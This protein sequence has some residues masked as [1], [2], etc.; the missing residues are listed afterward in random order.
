MIKERK[1]LLENTKVSSREKESVLRKDSISKNLRGDFEEANSEE[2]EDVKNNEGT[3]YFETPVLKPKRELRGK[4]KSTLG[5]VKLSPSLLNISQ[6]SRT[7]LVLIKHLISFENLKYLKNLKSEIKELIDNFKNDNSHTNEF[8]TKLNEIL[9]S[10]IFIEIYDNILTK[11]LQNFYKSINT[12]QDFISRIENI[13]LYYYKTKNN[14]T[15]HQL[16]NLVNFLPNNNNTYKTL[17]SVS[18]IKLSHPSVEEK[19]FYYN[20]SSSTNDLS[21][22]KLKK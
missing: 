5:I 10:N 8:N 11:Y 2:N 20:F 12:N 1:V 3:S 21:P 13:L 22:D 4:F 19:G 14:I 15:Q 9:K 16:I 18:E 6:E 7:K 17:N